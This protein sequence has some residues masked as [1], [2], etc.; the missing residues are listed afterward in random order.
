MSSGSKSIPSAY[1]QY[2]MSSILLHNVLTI[3]HFLLGGA[4]FILGYRSWL[5][6]LLGG[7][8]LVFAFGQMYLLMPLLVCRHCEYRFQ[9]DGRCI[10]GNNLLARAIGRPGSLEDFPRRA[11][12]VLCHNNLYLAALALPVL[13]LIPALILNFSW[14]VLGILLSVLGLLLVRMFVVIPRVACSRCR[15]APICPNAQAM[16][17]EGQAS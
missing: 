3:V 11:Q 8:Y 6:Y 17:I 10:S 15:S 4:G 5:G 1:T 7:L 13:G 12:G 14:V 2:P 9:E 16:G